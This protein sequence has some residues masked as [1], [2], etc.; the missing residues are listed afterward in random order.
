MARVE[1]RQEDMRAYNPKGNKSLSLYA[2]LKEFKSVNKLSQ[3]ANNMILKTIRTRA[4][5][6]SV[7][8]K[9]VNRQEEKVQKSRS[10]KLHRFVNSCYFLCSIMF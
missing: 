7:T 5:P 9:K 3:E 1:A 2:L 6:I 10:L 4:T 8:R